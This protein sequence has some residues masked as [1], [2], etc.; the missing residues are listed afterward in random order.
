[1]GAAEPD[2]MVVR[3]SVKGAVHGKVL[4][5][6]EAVVRGT[7]NWGFLTQW[8]ETACRNEVVAL[9]RRSEEVVPAHCTCWGWVVDEMG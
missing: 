1:M 4:K 5:Q 3:T 7:R 8:Q 6:S 9:A 2:K